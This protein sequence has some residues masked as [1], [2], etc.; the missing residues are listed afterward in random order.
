MREQYDRALLLKEVWSEPMTS[1]APRYGMSDVGLKKLCS[2]LQ[3]PSP[4]RGYWAKLKA[5][6]TVE[7][8]PKLRP[9]T[10]LDVHLYKPYI[11]PGSNPK[12][13]STPPKPL[14]SRLQTILDYEAD[15]AH[16]IVVPERMRD[17]HTLTIK[18]QRA[19]KEAFKDQ[20]DFPRAPGEVLDI[21]VSESMQARALRVADA[22]VKALERRGYMVTPGKQST[23]VEILGVQVS[24]VFFESA[25]R[26]PYVPTEAEK[27]KIAR[28]EWVW[29][30]KWQHH[31]SGK[32]QVSADGGY[33]GQITDGAQALVED[34]LNEVVCQMARRAVRFLVAREEAAIER[35]E[36]NRKRA[37]ALEKKAIQDAERKRMMTLLREAKQ[38]K[39]ATLLREYLDAKERLSLAGGGVTEDVA[40][41][42]RWGRAKADWLDPLVSA[43]DPVLDQVIQLP[44]AEHWH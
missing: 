36:R 7:P 23:R 21:R 42:L 40:E 17:P 41:E 18:T 33:S 43:E 11:L 2:R 12:Q 37:L 20:R 5:G 38:W 10:G 22:F 28:N 34:R 14:D 4:S 6:K 32:L 29:I 27:K 39:R 8:T 9:Y 15:P 24:L 44:Y 13:S 26:I 16:R 3:I 31:P 25:K 30:P 1:V 35:E 19:F